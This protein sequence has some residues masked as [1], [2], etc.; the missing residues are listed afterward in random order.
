MAP[1]HRCL[2]LCH[3]A[4]HPLDAA[5][6]NPPAAHQPRGQWRVSLPSSAPDSSTSRR[7]HSVEHEESVSLALVVGIALIYLDS[8]MHA[9][10]A[11]GCSWWLPRSFPSAVTDPSTQPHSPLWL[12]DLLSCFTWEGVQL[13][14]LEIRHT[15]LSNR[16]AVFPPDRRSGGGLSGASSAA[17]QGYGGQAPSDVTQPPPAL[18]GYVDITCPYQNYQVDTGQYH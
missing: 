5:P 12:G 14:A 1:R 2:S 6:Q 17:P 18:T 16:R 8:L 15:A 3:R 10:T 4:A 7:L 13:C 11:T 9:T